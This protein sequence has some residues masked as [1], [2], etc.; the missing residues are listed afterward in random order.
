[1]GCA[2]PNDGTAVVVGANA[3]FV[4]NAGIAE[5]LFGTILLPSKGLADGALENVNKAG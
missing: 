3:L 5:V 4:L 2:N 1:M